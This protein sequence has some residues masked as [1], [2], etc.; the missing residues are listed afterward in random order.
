L[1]TWGC[2]ADANAI[3][4][5]QKGREKGPKMRQIFGEIEG[6][7]QSAGSLGAITRDVPRPP[8]TRKLEG[9]SGRV[10]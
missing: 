7:A 9:L 3:E 1:T 6:T 5:V 4:P 8:V 10:H 2:D